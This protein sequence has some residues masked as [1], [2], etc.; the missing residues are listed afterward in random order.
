MKK[1][2]LTKLLDNITSKYY[3]NCWENTDKIAQYLLDSEQ[4]VVLPCKIGT[5]IYHIDLE[6]SEE[7]LPCCDCVENH[8]GFGEF[9]C[10]KNFFGWPSFEDKLCEPEKTCPR[11]KPVVREETFTLSFW[12]SYEKYFNR[13][14]F[15][16]EK[17]A[18]TVLKEFENEN[19]RKEENNRS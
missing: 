10:D 14:W 19:S 17:E 12:S 5:T 3:H 4:V 16:T 15:L 9:Y 1:N 2:I 6:I 11:F 18:T 13:T 8:S 7:E